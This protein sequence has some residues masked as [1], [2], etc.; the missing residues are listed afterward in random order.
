MNPLIA[1]RS[2]HLH[3]EGE[4]T[5]AGHLRRCRVERMTDGRVESTGTVWFEL[6]REIEPPPVEDAEPFLMCLLLEAMQEGRTLVAHGR[7]SP[8]LLSNLT[9]YRDAWCNW[10]PLSAYGHFHRIE[11]GADEIRPGEPARGPD[12]AIMAF[13]GGV[14]SSFTLR[15][16]H[17][18]QAGHRTVKISGCVMAHG[19]DFPL[20]KPEVFEPNFRR[21]QELLA[22]LGYA[23][24]RGPNDVAW[25][26]LTHDKP[27]EARALLQ[28]TL[29]WQPWSSWTA[30][31]YLQRAE[32]MIDK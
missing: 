25:F 30:K 5:S 1:G 9:E 2:M 11:F 4:S 21:N 8:M 27:A 3:L 14:D 26:Y 29:E 32:Q 16:H 6:P 24:R 7:V 31:N 20:S 17:H 13:S 19:F 10:S 18:R 23:L 28:K 15:R 22:S 12:L